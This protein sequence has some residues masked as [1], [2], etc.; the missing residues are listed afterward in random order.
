MK[1]AT[2]GDPGWHPQGKGE[3]R[4]AWRARR[5]KKEKYQKMPVNKGN[6]M[7]MLRENPQGKKS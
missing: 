3:L 4:N 2:G 7:V 5:G 1:W 6:T